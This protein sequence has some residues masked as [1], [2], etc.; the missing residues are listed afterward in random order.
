M[1][2]RNGEGVEFDGSARVLYTVS[3]CRSFFNST[4]RKQETHRNFLNVACLQSDIKEATGGLHHP[5]DGP[6]W[7]DNL[8]VHGVRQLVLQQA[9]V[10]RGRVSASG[11]V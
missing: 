11:N 10:F 3:H 5:F 1:A 4:L 2:L 9:P 6:R 7:D 8:V